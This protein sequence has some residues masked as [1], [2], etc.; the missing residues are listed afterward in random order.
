MSSYRSPHVPYVY[1]TP[2]ALVTIVAL[3]YP[4]V[5]AIKIGFFEWGNC[6]LG[7]PGGVWRGH[8]G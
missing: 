4:I 7:R 5:E 1:I 3:L 8:G 2:A 6:S